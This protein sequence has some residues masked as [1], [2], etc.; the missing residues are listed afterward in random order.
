MPHFSRECLNTTSTAELKWF[1]RSKTHY[2]GS[3]WVTS[4]DTHKSLRI[5]S[6]QAEK[7]L[8]REEVMNIQLKFP[9]CRH[10]HS[11]S[12]LNTILD[13]EF[14]LLSLP[15]ITDLFAALVQDTDIQR[16]NFKISSSSVTDM[17]ATQ[18]KNLSPTTLKRPVGVF[19]QRSLWDLQPLIGFHPCFASLFGASPICPSPNSQKDNVR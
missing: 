3:P 9:T 15:T 16:R 1:Y 12:S 19:T 5:C 4:A 14:C 2:T 17:S 18:Q 7:T 13:C 6:R 8:R 10:Q 11:T